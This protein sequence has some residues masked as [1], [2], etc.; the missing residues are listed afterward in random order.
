MRTLSRVTVAVVLAASLAACGD[1]EDKDSDDTAE[2]HTLACRSYELYAGAD[3]KRIAAQLRAVVEGTGSY[4]TTDVGARLVA[5]R[6]AAA[7]AG[8]TEELSTEDYRLFRD[9]VDISLE[10]EPSVTTDTAD[11]GLDGVVVAKYAGA[12]NALQEACS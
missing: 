3:G 10:L 6:A 5:V 4:N 12:V 1:S 8:L 7:K 2:A 9:L 11:V